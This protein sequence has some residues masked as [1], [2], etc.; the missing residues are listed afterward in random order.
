MLFVI[1]LADQ[2][3]VLF[4]LLCP[5]LVGGFKLAVQAFHLG[6]QFSIARRDS[7]NLVE[8]P[9][10]VL[11]GLHQVLHISKLSQTV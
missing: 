3:L 10:S 4:F 8:A 7:L 2:V 6:R 5:L 1:E 9:L 11:C